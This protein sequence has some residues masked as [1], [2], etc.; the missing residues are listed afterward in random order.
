M[1]S[2]LTIS[3]LLISIPAI[4]S[5]Q[6]RAQHPASLSRAATKEAERRLS[7]LGY[8]TGPVDGL[9]DPAT[10]SALLAFQKCEGRQATGRLTLDE[11]EAI[12][13]GAAPQA[14]ESGYEHVEVDLD[15]Q[16]LLLVNDAGSVRVLPVSTGNDKSFMDEGQPTIAYTP[17]GRFIVYDKEVGW[18]N[19]PLGSVYY[20]NYI[21]GGVAIHGSRSVPNEPASHGCIRIPMFAA[22]ELSKL[23]PV[24]SIV[25]VYDKVAFVSGKAWAE[26][27]ELK[28]AAL[29]STAFADPGDYIQQPKLS[30]RAS[31][32]KKAR[33]K[34]IRAGSFK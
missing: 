4:A 12:R 24:G 13:T 1:K 30:T 33:S 23:L 25:L 6:R 3:L 11:L 27:P 19:G 8:W 26:N 21:S 10:R 16:V 34:M 15:R 29:A 31:A 28:Q 32:I 2:L 9:F 22:R 14:R 17:R 7:E 5:A 20:A 18:G